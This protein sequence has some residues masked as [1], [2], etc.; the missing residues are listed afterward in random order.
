MRVTTAIL[1]ILLLIILTA[2]ATPAQQ[3]FVQTVTKLN[4]SCNNG[5]SVLDVPELNGNP[6]AIIFVT[7]ILVNGV[8]PDPHPIGAYFMY[9]K[10]WSIFNLDQTPIPEG[11][12]FKVE[13]FVGPAE[14]RFVYV[15][16]SSNSCLDRADLNNNPS[17]QL[18][19][20]PTAIPGKGSVFN[21]NDFKVEYDAAAL[22]WCI[23]NL[24]NT[25]APPGTAYNIFISSPGTVG[26][27]LP[28]PSPAPS[29][30]PPAI[31]SATPGV[32]PAPRPE[33][34]VATTPAQLPLNRP[35]TA[36]SAVLTFDSLN[37][38][39][40]K[41]LPS[42]APAPTGS[43]DL[44]AIIMARQISRLDEN[45]LPVLLTALQTAGFSIIDENRKVLMK[46]LGDGKGQGLAIYD[47]EAVGD[48]KMAKYGIGTSLEKIAGGITRNTPELSA[49]QLSAMMLNELRDQSNSFDDPY[50]RFWARL[51]IELGKLS[52]RP[53]DLSA[54]SPANL[55]ISMLQATLW[56]RRLQGDFYALETKLKQN[57]RARPWL[58]GRDLF[59]LA[60]NR[61]NAVSTFRPISFR[62]A[63]DLP[64]NLTDNESLVL[65]AGANL[66]TTWHGWQVDKLGLGKVTAGLY[67]V[68]LALA[69]LKLVAAVTALHGDITVANTPLIRTLNS[70]P[71]Q[72]RLM[73][74]KITMEV[75]HKQT[76]NCLRPL[77]NATT[78]LDFN[79]PTDGP[80]SGAAV[81]WHFAGDNDT[82]VNDPGAINTAI[83]G[84]T[85][86]GIEKFVVFESPAGA[87]K[88]PQNQVTDNDGLTKMW[89]VG[90]AKIPE[91]GSR[92]PVEVPK[93]AKVLVGVTLKSAKNPGQQFVDI[94][95]GA[96]GIATG[97]PLGLLM[98]IPEI[99]Y[100]I[101][102]V[103]AHAEIPV[104]DH[105]PCDGEWIGTITY[106][107]VNNQVDHITV[108]PSSSGGTTTDGG[109]KN[110]D[111][112][113]TRS[114]SMTVAGLN[115]FA[116]ESYDLI[117]TYD[118]ESHGTTPC[119]PG[120]A[121]CSG[122]AMSRIRWSSQRVETRYES[123]SA[124][125]RTTVNIVLEKDGY[126]ISV[127]PFD[128][129]TTSESSTQT[130]GRA[131]IGNHP[132]TFPVQ[133]Y[134]QSSS[135]KSGGYSY[136]VGK[137]KY[138]PDR[139][140]LSGS[141]TEKSITGTVT[142]ITWNLRRCNR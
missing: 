128:V 91:V 99:G 76:L 34:K 139:N 57:G 52:S 85:Q 94:I 81:E 96:I 106:T 53:A 141:S 136:I 35:A 66:I 119:C 64:C 133:S 123:G 45:S 75:G 102:Y 70:T 67:G 43:L 29:P 30:T 49:A 62:E 137:G 95:G 124:Q 134:S 105:E 103:P 2:S 120:A 115:A 19:T 28:K 65:D 48:L 89:L 121:A 27:S 78:G 86:L 131:C 140:V 113:S 39:V 25:P 129:P 58:N 73:T 97:G 84:P 47:F 104:I 125:D 110:S 7:P 83:F 69:W 46:P 5:C 71:G 8:N 26:S 108:P 60:E 1:L 13:Y 11:A 38:F 90:A 51:I 111:K 22:K 20:F 59:A 100:R 116:D 21:S 17:A 114:G 23:A 56:T 109:H 77:L 130:S 63:D 87:D 127:S 54:P 98:L 80:V 82:R 92:G 12:K 40:A 112:T 122:A 24:N 16:Q 126:K 74:A 41:G 118:G 18:R 32:Q 61:E 14:D 42:P 107:A 50:A 135:G 68:N 37:D 117:Y 33:S 36:R 3:Q 4:K 9:L 31:I 10:K 15:A 138:G 132:G 6:A 101:P 44:A 88:N 93:T 72:R 55:N 79:F 142:T